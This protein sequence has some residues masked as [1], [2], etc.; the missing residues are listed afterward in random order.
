MLKVV[1]E[2]K[3]VGIKVIYEYRERNVK[4]R[5]YI[6]DPKKLN[7]DCFYLNEKGEAVIFKAN[8][9]DLIGESK[10]SYDEQTNNIKRSEEK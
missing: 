2:A 1:E 9:G 3:E 4:M 8:R 10:V 5:F 7:Q 6:D